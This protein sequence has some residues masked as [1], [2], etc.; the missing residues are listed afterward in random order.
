M[1]HDTDSLDLFAQAL[2]AEGQDLAARI[3]DLDE[4]QRMVVLNEIR[5]ALHE[6]SPMRDQP[7]DYVK[8]VPATTV[9]GNAYNPNHADTRAMEL[10]AK[11][12]G[13]DGFTQPI[14]V[15][16]EGTEP[17]T[18]EI[19]DGFHRHLVG[20]DM[21]TLKGW[22]PTTAIRPERAGLDERM[23]ATYRHN[24]AR[25]EHTIPGMSEFILDLSRRGKSDQAIADTL[26][27][28]LDEVERLRSLVGLAEAHAD[29]EFS[30]AWE[31]DGFVEPAEW[32]DPDDVY[33][34][35]ALP[36]EGEGPTAADLSVYDRPEPTQEDR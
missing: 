8:W 6:V 10:L 2:V 13:E 32:A 15:Y 5:A 17:G 1:S 35:F 20:R 25:G 4:S 12:V 21:D 33:D 7:V 26:S 9:R 11:S 19:V 31:P 29:E 24:K 34:P 18:I 16:P 28:D 22:L 27:M 23:A 3:A 30:A 36:Q 14:V